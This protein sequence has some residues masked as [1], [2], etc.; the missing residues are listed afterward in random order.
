[1]LDS[2]LQSLPNPTPWGLTVGQ[3]L[4]IIVVAA[5]LFVGFLVVRVVTRLGG[6]L[7]RLGC[8]AMIVFICGIISFMALYNLTNSVGK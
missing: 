6:L 8:A 1:M 7:F 4:G 5:V 3:T 2:L